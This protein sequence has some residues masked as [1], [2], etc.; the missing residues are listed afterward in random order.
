[1]TRPSVTLDDLLDLVRRQLGV[2][3]VDAA[4][5]LQADLG[6]ESIDVQNLV[7]AVENR[8]N[9]VFDD[10]ELECIVSVGDLFNLL[11]SKA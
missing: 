9:V 8:Y 3:D 7:T 10:S 2:R 1:M 6:A 5:E 4:A 11:C